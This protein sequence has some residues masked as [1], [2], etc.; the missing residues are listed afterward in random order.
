MSSE[1][2]MTAGVKI[3]EAFETL[4]LRWAET[5]EVWN[6]SAANR[7]E[8]EQLEKI[9]PQVRQALDAL[10]RFSEVAR[11]AARECSDERD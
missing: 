10:N 2:L 6:D 3:R 8:K 11:R 1:S 4:E 9:G 5:R 7:F